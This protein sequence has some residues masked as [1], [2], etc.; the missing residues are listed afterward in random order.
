MNE[1]ARKL[2]ISDKNI[3]NYLEDIKDDLDSIERRL[4]DKFSKEPDDE[5]IIH[6][7]Q[8]LHHW[9]LRYAKTKYILE[10]NPEIFFSSLKSSCESY[11]PYLE[12]KILNTRE[13]KEI[14]L[15][16]DV[17][18]YQIFSY[19]YCDK[20][21]FQN[22]RN[23]VDKLPLEDARY[24]SD[25]FAHVVYHLLEGEDE[26]AKTAI[27]KF[28]KHCKEGCGYINK[29]LDHLLA[30]NS[31]GF[32]LMMTK[33]LEECFDYDGADLSGVVDEQEYLEMLAM[34]R[35]LSAEGL[36][37]KVKSIAKRRKLDFDGIED[38]PENE[39]ILFIEENNIFKKSIPTPS[40]I[41]LYNFDW[42]FDA[43]LA[44]II[45]GKQ[46]GLDVDVKHDFVPLELQK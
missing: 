31:D 21:V 44:L 24:G 41:E 1:V 3:E 14:D 46:R 34:E 17:W 16:T 37:K 35:G 11:P 30:K 18:K 25:I 38:L 45:L 20:E 43:A 9:Y 2:G 39:L 42:I 23:L 15:D 10:E 27:E 40:F 7:L 4:K 8:M 29:I 26:M 32:N 22:M 33:F 19:A 5:G 12:E 28:K 36:I 6:Q 13:G